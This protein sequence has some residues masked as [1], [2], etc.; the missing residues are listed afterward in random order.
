MAEQLKDK[1][2]DCRVKTTN[3]VNGKWYKEEFVKQCFDE[4]KKEV[5]SWCEGKSYSYRKELLGIIDAKTGFGDEKDDWNV[6]DFCTSERE[7]FYCDKQTLKLLKEKIMGDVDK[8]PR[9]EAV[10]F[11]E[12]LDKRFGF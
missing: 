10:P 4:I 3:I 2:F 8:V 1:V 9:F 7:G 6:K 12:I 11:R 5:S